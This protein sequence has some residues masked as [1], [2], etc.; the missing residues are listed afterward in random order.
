MHIPLEQGGEP[1]EQPRELDDE[2]DRFIAGQLKELG[3][4]VYDGGQLGVIVLIALTSADSPQGVQNRQVE[5]TSQ[6]QGALQ[7]PAES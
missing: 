2:E 1:A 4:F 6:V 5:H 3:H 7:T